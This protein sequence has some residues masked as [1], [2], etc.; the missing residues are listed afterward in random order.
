MSSVTY[1][2]E[3][4]TYRG[5]SA[6]EVVQAL[7]RDAAAYP[8]R[9]APLCR[10]LSWSLA[11]L[12]DSIP[13]RDLLVSPRLNDETLALWFLSLCDEYGLGSLSVAGHEA[14]ANR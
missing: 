1:R 2:T 5:L 10:F 12:A 14:E 7:E 9:G 4:K 11:Q 6:V 8:E 13:S 3:A